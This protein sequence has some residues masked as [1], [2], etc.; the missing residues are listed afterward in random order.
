MVF[1]RLTGIDQF[2]C[3]H[4]FLAYLGICDAKKALIGPFEM[5]K[6]QLLAQMDDIT[7]VLLLDCIGT[8]SLYPSVNI[9]ASCLRVGS[10]K[11]DW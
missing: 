5:T 11:E 4:I 2:V 6:G 8:L 3:H 9:S 10:P 1:L 7:S